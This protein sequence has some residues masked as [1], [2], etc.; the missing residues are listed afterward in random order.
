MMHLHTV[1]TVVVLR[2]FLTTE[3]VLSLK[4]NNYAGYST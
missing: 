4:S 1:H 3:K 2:D